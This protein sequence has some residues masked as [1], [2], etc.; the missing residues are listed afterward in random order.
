MISAQRKKVI[1]SGWECF[2]HPFPSN[3]QTEK[4]S[5]LLKKM[6]ENHKVD[7]DC[8]KREGV[9]KLIVS[10][11]NPKSVHYEPETFEKCR[12]FSQVLVKE[13]YLR[14]KSVMRKG[15]SQM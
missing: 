11:T 3:N 2:C 12:K 4:Y 7:M 9:L 14:R 13:M 10:K 5:Q 15:M 8:I 1:R 6:V